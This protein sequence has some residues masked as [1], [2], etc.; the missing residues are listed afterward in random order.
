[1]TSTHMDRNLDARSVRTSIFALLAVSA[2]VSV[3]ADAPVDDHGVELTAVGDEIKC[4][5]RTSDK[6]YVTAVD[7]GGRTFDT[8]HTDATS[9]GDFQTFTFVETAPSIGNDRIRYGIRTFDGHYLSA[10][11]GGGQIGDVI[12]TD[13][14]SL[15]AW[16]SF[17]LSS[18]Q[19]GIYAIRTD[20]G[21]YLTAVSGGGRTDDAI[22]TNVARVGDWERFTL[23]CE[24]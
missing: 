20:L 7:G 21:H 23:V 24:L 17:T 12:H 11:N 13:S 1:M 4:A 19:L 6:H 8:V 2:C 10:V 18:R 22:H 14:T 3:E 16:E 5:I 9:V 15:S